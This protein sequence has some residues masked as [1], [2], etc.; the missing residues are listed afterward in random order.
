MNR[1]EFLRNSRNWAC[2]ACATLVV[3]SGKLRAEEPK[4]PVDELLKRAVEQDKFTKNW[5]TD[6]FDTIE[7][8]CDEKTKMKLIEGCGRGCYNRHKF[9]QD[10][11][12]Q[13]KGDIDKLI[14]AY[15]KNFGVKREGD[16]VHLYYGDHCYCPAAQGRPTRP[17][18]IQCECTRATHQAVFEAALGKK[19][20]ADVAESIRR[21]GKTCHIRIY[22]S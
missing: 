14:A 11:A 13:G 10:I 4:T 19:F 15:S 17:N 21:G 20:R 12:E 22:L 1:L 9:K 6:L 18:D 16:V 2:A 8:E 3:G 5:M 7:A